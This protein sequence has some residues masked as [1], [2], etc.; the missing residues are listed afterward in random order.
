MGEAFTSYDVDFTL[1]VEATGLKPDSSYWYQFADCTNPK[2]ASVVGATRTL[3][4]P[5]SMSLLP[6]TCP[7]F[8]THA[9]YSTR[10]EGQRRKALDF[11]CLLVFQLPFRLLQRLHIRCTEHYVRYFH[12]PR[13]LCTCLLAIRSSM[14]LFKN[15][16]IQIYEY[17]NDVCECNYTL[18]IRINHQ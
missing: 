6:R 11:R 18:I 4:S 9:C 12:S 3:A 1:K 17:A 15:S 8:D 14:R 13:R 10:G 16:L 7:S 2:T 5:D